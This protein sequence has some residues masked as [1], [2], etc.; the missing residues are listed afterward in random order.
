MSSGPTF[1]QNNKQLTITID[2]TEDDSFLLNFHGDEALS[3]P[4][5]YRL[6]LLSNAEAM[7]PDSLLGASVGV[8]I[9]D[10]YT[11]TSHGFHG[12]VLR[13]TRETP[14]NPDPNLFE[15][16]MELVPDVWFL[17]YRSTFRILNRSES[18]RYHCHSAR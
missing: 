8:D 16:R 11:D 6:H 4:F 3:Q 5:F 18:V 15:Y 2:G 13:L 9:H 14:A 17:K 12:K 10:L 7:D 1:S